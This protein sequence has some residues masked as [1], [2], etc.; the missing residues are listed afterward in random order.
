FSA[1]TLGIELPIAYTIWG[2]IGILG[3]VF[4]GYYF[5]GQRLKPIGIIDGRIPKII[6][7]KRQENV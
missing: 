5:F 1:Y 7:I 4:S 3:S 6:K 2:V